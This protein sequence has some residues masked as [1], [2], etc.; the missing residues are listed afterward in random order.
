[1]KKLIP[2]LVASLLFNLPLIGQN[3]SADLDGT[4]G[5]IV[6]DSTNFSFT[7]LS[8]ASFTMWVNADWSSGNNY[9]LDFAEGGGYANGTNGMRFLLGEFQNQIR[10]YTYYN[11]NNTQPVSTGSIAAT[12][13]EWIHVAAVIEAGRTVG[14]TTTYNITL[15]VN[16]QAEGQGTK[17]ITDANAALR[18]LHLNAG[19][20]LR[21]GCR[22]NQQN[23]SFLDGALD[24]VMIYDRALSAA[25]VMD[26]A[27]NGSGPTNGRVIYYNFNEGAGTKAFDLSGGGHDGNLMGGYS[28]SAGV[29]NGFGSQTP[30]AAW[31]ENTQAPSLVV[32]FQNQTQGAAGH[33]WK[34]GD[35]DSSTQTNPRHTYATEGTYNVCLTSE[36]VCGNAS[37][38]T[39]KDINVDCPKAV[40]AFI[41]TVEDRKVV[42]EADT[43]GIQN[44]TWT[45]SDGT[46]DITGPDKGTASKIFGVYGSYEVCLYVSS[47]CGVDT[48]CEMIPV[49]ASGIDESRLEASWKI[50]PNP[51][52][53]MVYVSTTTP[54]EKGLIVRDIS[55]R[56][57]FETLELIDAEYGL[58]LSALEAGI[59][60]IEGLTENHISRKQW[61]K[62]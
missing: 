58:D 59:Y 6:V 35:G 22:W 36:N 32:Q 29:F 5:R 20:N 30:T 24:N 42:F 53:G 41:Y 11:Q 49:F 34:F 50:Y 60:Y 31:N 13:N 57:V 56:V 45:F 3:T 40:S 15:Y 48:L 16:G 44:F 17:G 23:N 1:M 54:F 37:S 61:V 26:M 28:W 33:L 47:P 25:E 46:Q 2:F 21:L 10:L 43:N 19:S 18:D 52:S 51:S 38:P 7:R 9:L 4:D 55:G 14:T 39:C 27:C 12:A 8:A 62:E